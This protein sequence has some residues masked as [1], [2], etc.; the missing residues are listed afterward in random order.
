MITILDVQLAFFET[1]RKKATPHRTPDFAKLGKDFGMD[2]R[3]TGRL[4]FIEEHNTGYKGVLE[5]WEFRVQL[6]HDNK[7]KDGTR[8]FWADLLPGLLVMAPHPVFSEADVGD[9]AA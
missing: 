5:R 9:G 2:A 6:S 8:S 7:D 1:L 3:V 4:W